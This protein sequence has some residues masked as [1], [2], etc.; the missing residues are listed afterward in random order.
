MKISVFG[1]GY[2]GAVTAA[3]LADA[4]HTV[5]GVDPNKTKTDLVNSGQAPIIEKDVSQMIKDA[6]SAGHLTATDDS[7]LAIRSSD[8]S[9]V[10]VGTPSQQNGDLDLQYIER[11]CEEIGAAIS[12]KDTFHVVVIRSTMLPGSTRSTVIPALERSSGKK[13]GDSF[14]VCVNPEFLREGTAVYDYRNPPKTVIGEQDAESGDPMVEIYAHLDAPLI[15]SSIEVAEMTKYVDNSWHATKVAFGNEVGAICKAVGV[16]SHDVMNIFMQ[17]QKLNISSAYLLPGFAFGGSCLPKDLRAIN[18]K[19]KSLDLDVPLLRSVLP[20]NRV[21]IDR[22]IDMVTS[23]GN[24]KLSILGLSFK[25][26]T[27]DLRESPIVEITE[28][29]LGKGYDIQ[30][31]DENVELARLTGTNRDF[32]LNHIPHISNLLVNDIDQVLE[33][34]E[35]IIV[36][37][38]A[39]EFAA[40]IEGMGD[41]KHI[42][43]LVRISK[44]LPQERNYDGIAW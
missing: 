37:N 17:D 41:D 42:I 9:L 39:A 22:A 26:G 5:I 16:D 32:L 13:A 18:Y 34:G 12:Q 28:R 19:A 14:G 24:K 44:V 38:S 36:G 2:V 40:I 21:H 30:I 6:V 3:C 11:V 29:L 25:A 20:S 43:D 27:D 4:G 8:I 35:T 15:R 1:L 33:H 7:T 10:C 23:V 31:Y